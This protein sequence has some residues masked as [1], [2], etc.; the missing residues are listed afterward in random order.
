MQARKEERAGQLYLSY[1]YS[2]GVLNRQTPRERAARQKVTSE[3]KTKINAMRRR[4]ELMQLMCCNFCGGR[5]LFVC[6]EFDR[7]VSDEEGRAALN[8]FHRR[9][10]ER[11]DKLGAEYRYIV[12]AETHGRDGEPA[13]LHYHVIMSGTGRRMVKTICE[14]WRH[15]SVDVRTLRE[16]S[17]NFEDTCRYLL[18][19]RKPKNKR[20]YSCSRN[21][22]RP[23][24]P[25]RR[26][27]PERES[28]ELPPGVQLIERHSSEIVAG[29]YDIL[30]GK[31]VDQAAFDRYWARI[32]RKHVELNPWWRKLEKRRARRAP[33]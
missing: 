14:L 22:K 18:K 7:D 4:Y 11:W 21:L 24:E 27:I 2:I 10:R 20:A 17:D 26:K 28:G 15:G 19:E 12:I 30:V 32:K 31:I 6:L 29:R 33:I 25:V 1:Q 8:A 16:L 3:A 13:R 9:A 23:P 5:D